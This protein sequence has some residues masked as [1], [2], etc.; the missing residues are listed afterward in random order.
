MDKSNS[1]LES[2]KKDGK[3]F[4]LSRT[5]GVW[6]WGRE[7]TSLKIMKGFGEGEHVARHGLF[8]EKERTALPW[9]CIGVDTSIE[10]KNRLL[11]NRYIWPY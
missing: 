11:E 2:E 3:K 1:G 7:R 4:V 9:R 10:K 5:V 6:D 8:L